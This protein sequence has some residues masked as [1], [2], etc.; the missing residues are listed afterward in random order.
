MY[1]YGYFKK[2]KGG[3]TGGG[4]TAPPAS[5]PKMVSTELRLSAPTYI[6]AQYDQ[7]IVVSAN[8]KDAINVIIN[9]VSQKPISIVHSTNEPALIGFEVNK[10]VKLTDVVT[11]AYNDQHPIEFMK[12][13]KGIEV[14]NQ[15][16]GVKIVDDVTVSDVATIASAVI[17]NTERNTIVLSFDREVEIVGNIKTLFEITSNG[18]KIAPNGVSLHARDHKIL[19]IENAGGVD[20]HGGKIIS[21]E[22][23][24]GTGAN[25][26]VD[27]SSKKDVLS[28]TQSVANEIF[29]PSDPPADEPELDLDGDGL[30][31]TVIIE[32]GGAI[33]T[34][35]EDSWNIDL[36]G[37]GIADIVIEKSDD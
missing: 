32:T 17:T 7:E 3:F 18:V 21:I 16:Y 8:L 13:S 1:Q 25:K 28:A 24:G 14:E 33:V 30:L 34:E 10:P 12:S 31:D 26:L 27:A 15:T 2:G 22:Y 19:N 5:M 20:F 29:T 37:D 36:D 35:D 4:T 6:I 23:K 11:W 9:G